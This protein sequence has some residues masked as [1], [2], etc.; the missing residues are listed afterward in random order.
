MKEGKRKVRAKGREGEVWTQGRGLS[1]QE[2]LGNRCN[3]ERE[4]LK[5]N[6]VEL[7]RHCQVSNE[8][9]VVHQRE[10]VKKGRAH[11]A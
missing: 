8:D 2:R 1:Y 7:E 4:A 5:S 11:M 9:K 3:E 6:L 10:N